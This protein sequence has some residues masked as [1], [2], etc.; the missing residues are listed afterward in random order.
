ASS[1]ASACRNIVQSSR[2][3]TAD[4]MHIKAAARAGASI[5]CVTDAQCFHCGLPAAEPGR[6]RAPLLGAPR[7]FCCAGC[8]AVA[9]TIAGA[10]H[11]AYYE[12]R[13]QPG[14]RPRELPDALVYDDPQ[15]QRQFT[16][17]SAPH[18]RS[19]TLIFD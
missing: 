11:A 6:W 17:S 3:L 19:A 2:C 4:L 14:G 1:G 5:A 7:D 10:G 16:F 15:A 9:S 12:T 8:L 18:E 13:E